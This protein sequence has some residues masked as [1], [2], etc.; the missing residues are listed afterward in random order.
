[1]RSSF[2]I[3]PIIFAIAGCSSTG[4]TQSVDKSASRTLMLTKIETQNKSLA[5]ENEN[6]AKNQEQ[7]R[8]EFGKVLDFCKPILSGYEKNSEQQAR[9]AYWLSMSGLV[10]GTVLAPGL[11]AANAAS[12]AAAVAAL[13]GWAGATNFAGQ[14]LKTSGL[15]GSAIAQTRNDIIKNLKVEIVTATDGNKTFEERRG[16]L[17]RANAECILYDISVPTIPEAN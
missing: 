4:I 12:N 8:I 15:S 2:L 1:M 9:N 17:M 7:L 3:A 6:E 11:I 10:A 14:S 16:A 13:S 5:V